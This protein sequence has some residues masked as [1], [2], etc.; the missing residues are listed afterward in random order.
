[1]KGEFEKLIISL[2]PKSWID[3]DK[4]IPIRKPILKMIDEARKGSPYEMYKML[5]PQLD[6]DECEDFVRAFRDWFEKW[7]G[8]EK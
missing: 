4:E 1:M 6:R 5:S 8:D 2:I 7:F 3:I